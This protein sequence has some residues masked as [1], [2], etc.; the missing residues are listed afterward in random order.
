M[1]DAL[2]ADNEGEPD[3]GKEAYTDT[4]FIQMSSFLK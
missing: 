2:N 1:M 4:S 3:G